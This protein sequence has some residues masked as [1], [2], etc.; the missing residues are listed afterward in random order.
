MADA[1]RRILCRRLPA[2]PMATPQNVSPRYTKGLK[3][4]SILC[5]P[6][7]AM[8]TSQNGS[9]RCTLRL[10]AVSILLVKVVSGNGSGV[11]GG[12]RW[13]LDV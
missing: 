8:A 2:V 7:V 12:N 9:P 6:A 3:A 11:G 5:H 4:V 13:H 1:R 10:K